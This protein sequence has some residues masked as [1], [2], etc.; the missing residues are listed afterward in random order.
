MTEPAELDLDLNEYLQTVSIRIDEETFEFVL[1]ASPVLF[2]KL[3]RWMASFWGT[4]A[5]VEGADE[6]ALDEGYAL[7]QEMTGRDWSALK[8]TQLAALLRFLQRTGGRVLGKIQAI[9]PNLPSASPEPS[10]AES[11]SEIS[12]EVGGS[13]ELPST[14]S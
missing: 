9:L 10:M 5:S 8:S 4:V 13:S 1:D 11:P 6:A 2:G 14:S 7:A 3:D 12:S